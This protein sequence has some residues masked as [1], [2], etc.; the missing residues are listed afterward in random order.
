MIKRRNGKRNKLFSGF[1]T[2]LFVMLSFVTTATAVYGSEDEFAFLAEP[3]VRVG[4]SNGTIQEQL[5]R[6]RYPEAKIYYMEKFSG[7]EALAQGKIDAY[8]YDRKQMELA[9]ENGLEGVRLLDGTI[10]DPTRI[11]VGMS[12][13]SN[14]PDLENKLNSFIDELK[15]EGTLDDMYKRW[16][17]DSVH[18]MP[19]IEMPQSPEFKLVVGT[20]ADV[21]P[22]SFYKGD[23]IAGYDMEFVYRFAAYINA[24]LD[25]KVYDWE[26]IVAACKSGK[27]DIIASNLQYTPE[28]AEEIHYSKILYEEHNGVMVRDTGLSGGNGIGSFLTSVKSSFI[29]TFI[30]ENRYRMFLSGIYTTLLITVLSVLFGTILGFLVFM[31]CRG[32]S[33][34]ANFLADRSVRLV[35]GMP[36]VVLLMILY[37]IVFSW[38]DISGTIVAVIAFT[39]IFASGVLNMLRVSVGAVDRGQ[40]EAAYA[41]GYSDLWT[42]FRFILPQAM[43]RFLPVY[44]GELVSLIKATAVVGYIA[45]QDL[46]KMGDIVRSRTYEAFFPLIAVA[47]IYFFLEWLISLFAV[48]LEKSTDPKR[49]NKEDILKGIKTE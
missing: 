45:V 23:K 4:V 16:V 28:R 13:R 43:P 9:L 21:E 19:D 2:L 11:A 37:Y 48:K 49:R 35:L 20:T 18:E 22:Y 24:E 42:F 30:T 40:T 33:R 5:V 29:K 15:A 31:A 32:G 26:S 38:I 47:V 46:T 34:I 14:I 44:K 1:F 36:T 12:D 10:G 27:T 6:D 39:L 17:V 8:I 7:Y 25:I 3:G 41:L